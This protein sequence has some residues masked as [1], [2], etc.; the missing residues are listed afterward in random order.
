MC[1]ICAVQWLLRHCIHVATIHA[2][3]ATLRWRQRGGGKP[4]VSG[5][6]PLFGHRVCK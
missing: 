5:I 1:R 4:R 2:D 3:G 6:L